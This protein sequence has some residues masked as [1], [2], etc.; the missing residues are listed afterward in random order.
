[1]VRGRLEH[2]LGAIDRRPNTYDLSKAVQ[3]FLLMRRAKIAATDSEERGNR[4]WCIAAAHA[5]AGVVVPSAH[6]T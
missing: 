3:P 4:R 2:F 6:R 5:H 1:M